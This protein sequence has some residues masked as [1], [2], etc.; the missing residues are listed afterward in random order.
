[1]W[2]EMRVPFG[3]TR[4]RCLELWRAMAAE[5]AGRCAERPA[6]ETLIRGWCGE[7]RREEV[8]QDVLAGFTD[9]AYTPRA[10]SSGMIIVGAAFFFW[11]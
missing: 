1:M 10:A 2:E 5:L 11:L 6:S 3:K 9:C 8:N 7:L 4:M